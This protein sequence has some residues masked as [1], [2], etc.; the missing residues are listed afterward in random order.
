M[1]FPPGVKFSPGVNLAPRGELC[2][3]GL[4]FTPSFTSRGEHTL[5]F[6][7]IK[8][9]KKIFTPKVNIPPRE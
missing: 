5:L 9:E 3:L 7:R 2:A 8:V 1:C 6:R 4:M